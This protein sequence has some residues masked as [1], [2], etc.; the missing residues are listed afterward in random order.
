M[1]CKE[2]SDVVGQRQRFIGNTCII[3]HRQWKYIKETFELRSG[4]CEALFSSHTT[5][6]HLPKTCITLNMRMR[7]GHNISVTYSHTCFL[8]LILA[9]LAGANTSQIQGTYSKPLLHKRLGVTPRDVLTRS[10][11]IHCETTCRLTSW[12]V[13]A[14]LLPDRETCQLLTEEV[15]DDDDSLDSADGW[16][17]IRKY[18]ALP[19][20][21][22]ICGVF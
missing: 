2:K 1:G 16:K 3:P 13:A 14:N 22:L 9:L 21:L 18:K 11:A 7:T 6:L 8:L 10:S 17:Y 20:N 19:R 5:A 12:C 4:C 15:S